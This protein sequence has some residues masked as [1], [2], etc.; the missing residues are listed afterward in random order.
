MGKLVFLNSDFEFNRIFLKQRKLWLDAKK[1]KLIAVHAGPELGL[2]VSENEQNSA[3]YNLD[4]AL[5]L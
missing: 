1:K 2:S 3:E 4:P 5:K